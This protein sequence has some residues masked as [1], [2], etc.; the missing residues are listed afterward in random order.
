MGL[1]RSPRDSILLLLDPHLT[2]KKGTGYL[3][4]GKG[5]LCKI[6][7]RENREKGVVVVIWSLS[8]S[9]SCDPMDIACQAPL[10]MGFSRQ[11]YWSG[12]PSPSP[13]Q[14]GVLPAKQNTNPKKIGQRMAF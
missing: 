7:D 8:I 6:N 10:S 14:E 4:V 1:W 5:H 12:L 13:K 11:E 9:N 3:E 2:E